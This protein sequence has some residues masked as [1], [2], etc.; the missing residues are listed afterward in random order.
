MIKRS[1]Q[2]I[3][4][5]WLFR[6]KV[7]V[8]Y[9][10]R[11]VGKTTLAKAILK[12]YEQE[13][14]Y[15]NCE[16]Q[17]IR[18]IITQEEPM[19][20]KKFIGDKRIIVLDEAQN[21]PNIGRILKLLIDTYPEL[22]II[23]T[24][25]SSFDL[26]NKT[27]EPLT[28]RALQFILYPFSYQELNE[29]YNPFERKAQ[30]NNFLRYGMYPEII[31]APEIDAQILLD[32]LSSKY[33][34]QDILAFENLKRAD[35]IFKL[36]QLLALQIGSEVSLN[37]L[38]VTLQI[39]RKTV[40]KYI[41]LLEKAFV[42]F[43]LRAFSRNLRKEI[44]KGHKIYF[45]DIGV[46]NSIIQ[47]YQ[48]IDLRQDKGALWENFLIVERLK[49]LQNASI[50]LNNFFWRTHDR[51]EIDY[52]EEY[53]G[54]LTGYEIKWLIKKENYP[55]IFTETYPNSTVKFIDQNNFED[56]LTWE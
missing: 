27:S 56:F 28:G 17:S 14:G 49:I 10:A 47:Q 35:I 2:P 32:D 21:V 46:R 1:I 15:Y 44:T 4:E 5:R 11:Q 41:D 53:N 55:Q 51:Q 31:Q 18:S 19:L 12:K 39:N 29:L 20:I 22:Q 36:L 26:A 45:Y 43:R 3:I 8:L 33:L 9:G 42:I 34:Y 50:R 16:I 7:I 40:E 25:S 23:A 6:G 24:G 30:L 54:Q 52:L 37:E 38:A 13:D 48:P